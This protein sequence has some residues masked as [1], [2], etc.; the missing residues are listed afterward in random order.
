[1]AYPAS[2]DELVPD[3]HLVRVVSQT[4]D[5]MNLEP[6][7]KK[8]TKGGGASRYHPVMLLKVVVFG[9]MSG[10]YSSRHLA[11]AVRENVL[12]RWLTGNRKQ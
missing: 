11:R 4:S 1:M 10:I 5:E 2:V 3:I 9:Y 8:D 7:L 6:I 12:Y